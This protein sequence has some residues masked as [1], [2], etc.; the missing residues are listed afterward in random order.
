MTNNFDFEG[1]K[2]ATRDLLI[3]VGEDPD[4]PGL[5]ETPKRVAGA[6]AE[7]LKGYEMDPKQHLKMFDEDSKSLT[8]V[9]DLNFTSICEHHLMPFCGKI[10]VGYIPNGK[11]LGLSKFSR[12]IEVFSRRLQLQEKLTMEIFNFLKENL[13]PDFLFVYAIATHDCM[14][15]RGVN[16][17]ESHTET[18]ISTENLE[19]VG[20]YSEV[21]ELARGK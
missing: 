15:C 13:N 14:A 20:N 1:V 10:T 3:A 5:K 16:Q 19:R 7:L 8:I 2:K 9:R 12:I 21:M 17:K 6:W 4:R 11:V 18:L